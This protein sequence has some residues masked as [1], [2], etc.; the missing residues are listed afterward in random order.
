MVFSRFNRIVVIHVIFLGLTTTAF[1]WTLTQSSMI[2]TTYTMIIIWLGVFSHLT[3]YVK[4][5]NRELSMFLEAFRHRDTTLKFREYKE[6]PL[7]K[8]L[9]KEFNKVIQQFSLAR[10]ETE[11]QN[12]FF[13]NTIKH[14]RVGLLAFDEKG[15]IELINDAAMNLFKIKG[16]KNIHELNTIKPGITELLSK[17]LPGKMEL[18]KVYMN[19]NI[20]QLSLNSSTFI[21]KGKMIKLISI[22]D[23]KTE[24]EFGELEAWN[25]A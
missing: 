17:M 10:S 25:A 11:V 23:I 22:Q 7:F 4:K 16:I 24:L 15:N 13:Q 6:D 9:H 5:T 8:G 21:L 20:F 14:V 1:F 18:I 12:I 2:I 19:N 3:W